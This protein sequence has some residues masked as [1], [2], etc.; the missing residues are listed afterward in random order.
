MRN[1]FNNKP[2]RILQVIGIMNRGGAETMIMNLYRHIDRKKVQ[3]DFVQN[4]NDGAFFDEEIQSLG[5]RIYKC[6]R[7]V[8]T[9]YLSYKK[10][11]KTFFDIHKEYP[12]VHGHIGSTAAIYLSE[13]NKHNI[14]TIAHSHSIY[15]K[16]GKQLLYSILSYR[17]RNIADYLFMCSE[18]AGIDRYGRNAA[19]DQNRAF[20]VPNAIDIKAYR[21]DKTIRNNKRKEFGIE[22]TDYVVGHIGRFVE[23]KNHAFLLNVFVAIL[24]KCPMA[25]LLLVGDGELRQSIEEKIRVYGLEEKAIITGD[26][27]DVN[28]L[29]SAMDVMVFPSKYEGLPVTLVEAQCNGLPCIISDNIPED[30]ILIDDL[31]Q[32][33]SL[34]EDPSVWAESALHCKRIDRTMCADKIKETGFDIEKSAKWLEEFYLEKAK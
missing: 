22:D 14:I 11:W 25:K 27:S 34:E 33:R 30:C 26:R 12:I 7:F 18:R 17:T 29:L 4:E 15:I 31:I 2:V 23:V 6:P 32:V 8:G 5:G 16:S 3:F 20:L 13:A 28:E 1:N 24:N 9:N 10:W 21:F 19:L